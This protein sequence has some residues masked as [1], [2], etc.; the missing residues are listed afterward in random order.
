MVAFEPTL[1]V[2]LCRGDGTNAV[3][4]LHWQ[5]LEAQPWFH[6]TAPKSRSDAHTQLCANWP[7]HCRSSES[8]LEADS[9]VGNFAIMAEDG[10]TRGAL[11]SRS[12][13]P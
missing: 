9:T 6:R 1:H 4:D 7:R 3:L 8:M 11:V 10:A 5:H 13:A 2:A 12:I